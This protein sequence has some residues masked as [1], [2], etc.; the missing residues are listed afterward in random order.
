MTLQPL[1]SAEH[2][3][4]LLLLL[5]LLPL[6]L[7]PGC[8]MLLFLNCL[9]LLLSCAPPHLS[10][11]SPP[12]PPPLLLRWWE[13]RLL[14]DSARGEPN[15][16][17]LLAFP[18]VAVLEQHGTVGFF[19]YR[20]NFQIFPLRLT[21]S[22]QEDFFF[23]FECRLTGFTSVSEPSHPALNILHALPRTHIF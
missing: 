20:T 14:R 10:P 1:L 12:S 15:I 11:I 22:R 4:S 18:G 8:C 21:F 17:P 19:F 23:S 2:F 16:F 7:T 5:F 13:C 3:P 9:Q 6:V